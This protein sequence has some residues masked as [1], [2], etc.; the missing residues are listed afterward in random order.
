MASVNGTQK[1]I[2]RL[3]ER[4]P[5]CG[6]TTPY[7]A[8]C[9]EYEVTCSDDARLCFCHCEQSVQFSLS[10]DAV[11]QLVHEG[12]IRMTKSAALPWRL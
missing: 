2:A 3:S 12:R 6:D 8:P 4:L 1:V 9:G 11:M 5:L 10:I 7:S